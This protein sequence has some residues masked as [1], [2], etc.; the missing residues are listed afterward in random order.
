MRLRLKNIIPS[1]ILTL[2][3]LLILEII[4]STLL[5]VFGLINYRIP[6]N[7]LILLYIGFKLETPWIAL[8][9]LCIQYLHSFFSNEGWALGTFT[10]TMICI[11]VSYVRDLIHFNTIFATIFVTQIFQTLWF[12]IVSGMI[13]IQVNNTNLLIEKF[14]RFLPESLF[15]SIIS[16]VFYMILDRIW[17]SDQSEAFGEGVI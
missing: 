6:F 10:G 15:I 12:L 11:L 3:F 5:P 14:W 9:I 2:I 17:K 1:L 16:P 4:S 7:V 8:L 13:Y